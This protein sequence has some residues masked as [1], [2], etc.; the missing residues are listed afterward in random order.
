MIEHKITTE[1]E[2]VRARKMTLVLMKKL[3]L[4]GLG[5]EGK[6]LEGMVMSVTVKC[7]LNFW[8]LSSLKLLWIL[9][10]LTDE[11]EKGKVK[12]WGSF[13]RSSIS[14]L[15]ILISFLFFTSIDHCGYPKLIAL[16]L[17]N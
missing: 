12:T 9:I 4:G 13:G 6:D 7:E 11:E 15:D 17:D 8:V 5:L 3:G 1:A 2:I 14:L 10:T 16:R